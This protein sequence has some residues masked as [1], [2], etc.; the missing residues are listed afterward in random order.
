MIEVGGG[1]GRRGGGQ[2]R[3]RPAPSS[4][5]RLTAEEERDLP[6]GGRHAHRAGHH[7]LAPGLREFDVCRT[8]FD[9]LNRNLIAPAGTGAA[10]VA[11]TRRRPRRGRPPTP[12]YVVAAAGARCWPWSGVS[13]QRR[14]AVRGD[15]ACRRS[16]QT[17]TTCCCE[18]VSHVAAA[19]GSTGRSLA[20]HL[21]AGRRA[22]ARSRSWWT[23]ASSTAAYLKDPWARPYHYALD[24]QR[25]PAERGGR[26]RA[27]RAG[28]R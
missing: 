27:R 16:S 9:L 23:R 21:A 7:R 26:R 15:R 22:A 1:D 12:G 14:H 25:L 8:L 5:I 18:G 17:P 4:K 2:A 19:S 10:Q 3:A 13:V 24:R 20:Y 28:H 11:E 6:Q